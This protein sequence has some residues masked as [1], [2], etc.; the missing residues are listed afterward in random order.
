MLL[1]RYFDNMT[2]VFKKEA[3]ACFPKTTTRTV[4]EDIRHHF[5]QSIAFLALMYAKHMQMNNIAAEAVR[6]VGKVGMFCST[7]ATLQAKDTVT[8]GGTGIS[9]LM[10]GLATIPQCGSRSLQWSLTGMEDPQEDPLTVYCFC[11]CSGS[12][13]LG[14]LLGVSK[15]SERDLLSV[16]SIYHRFFYHIHCVLSRFIL[17]YVDEY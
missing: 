2:V 17:L 16:L 3:C 14:D 12:A 6:V 11:V 4:A 9:G 15:S 13:L 1:I 7:K 10:R 8:A 5:M